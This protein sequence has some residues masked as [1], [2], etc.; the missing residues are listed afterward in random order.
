MIHKW[1]VTVGGMELRVPR[2][3]STQTK[4]L[5]PVSQI[6]CRLTR[7]TRGKRRE[8]KRGRQEDLL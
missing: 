5:G 6:R 8:R 3:H 7:I 4:G 2:G 1:V